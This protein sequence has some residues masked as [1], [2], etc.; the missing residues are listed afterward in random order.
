MTDRLT[1]DQLVRQFHDASREPAGFLTGGEF[2]RH[3]LTEEGLPLP[4]FGRPGVRALLESFAESGWSPYFE[5]EFLI[6]LQRGRASITLEPGGQ[7]ELSGAPHADLASLYDEASSFAQDVDR[8]LEGSGVKQVALGFT[9]FARIPDVPW[10]PKGRYSVMREHLGRVGPLAH[11]MMKG[12]C[13]VQAS[14]DWS[15][16]ADCARKVQLATALGPLTTALFAN[17]PISEGRPNGYM[18]YRGQVWT[19]TDPARTGLPDAAANFSFEAWTNYLLDVPMMFYK[20]ANQEWRPAEG[21]TFRHWMDDERRPPTQADWEL[22]LTSVFPEVRVKRQIEVRGADCVP[23]PMAMG[24]VGLFKGLF[25]CPAAMDEATALAERFLQE[26]SREDRFRTACRD[27]LRGE[28]GGRKLVVWAEELL[29]IADAG[30]ERCAP[31]DRRWLK[32]LM[33]Q[34]ERGESPARTLLRHWMAD[35][36][37]PR[38]LDLADLQRG[39][40]FPHPTASLD[41]APA[42]GLKAAR[43]LERV[44]GLCRRVTHALR[45]RARAGE[46]PVAKTRRQLK[47]LRRVLHAEEQRSL[48]Q[49]LGVRRFIVLR[50]LLVPVED[51]LL[52]ALGREH[53]AASLRHLRRLARA[54][55]KGLGDA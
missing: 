23:L 14:F 6:A 12:T 19:Q 7:F 47:K 45:D 22:H 46:W 31:N 40:A 24:F 20:D 53:D 42:R 30:L 41:R 36:T 52:E 10:V 11:H 4:Y 15:D 18:S 38:L 48:E 50:D 13:A 21:R 34:V 5:G 16:E 29:E 35:P 27:G 37:V 8:L 3:L 2:E 26:Q 44:A 1:F 39:D 43:H 33:T 54:T 51:A 25:Y 49:G 17:S 55:R 28:V 9:P 32:P